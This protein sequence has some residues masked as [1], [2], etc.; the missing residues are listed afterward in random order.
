MRTTIDLDP[1]VLR[2]LKDRSRAEGKSLGTL[3]SELLAAA[4]GESRPVRAPALRWTARP[5]RARVNLEDDEAVR[6]ALAAD[7]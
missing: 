4:L 6:A 1:T 3:A 5:M 2:R 7:R